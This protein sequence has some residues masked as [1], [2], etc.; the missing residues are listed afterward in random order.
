MPKHGS[1]PP[2]RHATCERTNYHWIATVK[3][4]LHRVAQRAD[5][6][7]AQGN[8]GRVQIDLALARGWLKMDERGTYVRMQPVASD[9]SKAPRRNRNFEPSHGVVQMPPSD[10]PHH[11]EVN[12]R[13][14][15]AGRRRLRPPQGKALAPA[16]ARRTSVMSR[17]AA[18]AEVEPISP[19]GIEL[20]VQQSSAAA[21]LRRVWI[22]K[23]KRRVFEDDRQR[24]AR[25]IAG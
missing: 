2:K 5:A 19:E 9:L 23:L 11:T 17:R 4:V 24:L 3:V 1:L 14:R 10:A 22:A 6:A 16:I 8:A 13:D 18:D 12:L 25:W 7:R 21:G 20:L 15:L